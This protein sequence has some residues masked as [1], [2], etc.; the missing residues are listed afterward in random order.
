M[1]TTVTIDDALWR[2]A[3][4]VTPAPTKRALIEMGLR[5]L[6]DGAARRR[7]IALA[8]TMPDI[9]MPPRRSFGGTDS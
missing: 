4:R 3:E 6:V 8:G 9:E 1:R 5:A 2:E 7:A